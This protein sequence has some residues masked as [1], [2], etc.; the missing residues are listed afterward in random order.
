MA[1][2]IMF[3]TALIARRGPD[4]AAIVDNRRLWHGLVSLHADP[5]GWGIDFADLESESIHAWPCPGTGSTEPR[6][7]R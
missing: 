2:I 3:A 6:R 7:A 4:A 5:I 1:R